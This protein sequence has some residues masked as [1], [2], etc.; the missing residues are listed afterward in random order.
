MKIE[1]TSLDGVLVIEPE[2]SFEDHRGKTVCAFEEGDLVDALIRFW[3]LSDGWPTQF[4]KHN[5][6]VSYKNVLRGIHVSNCYKLAY[7]PFGSIYLVA[8]DCREGS[9]YFGKWLAF[10]ID[11]Y[12]YNLKMILI[13]PGFGLAHLVQSQVAVFFY[14]WSSSF[15]GDKQGGYRWDS[16]GIEWPG[17]SDKFNISERD[18]NA[19]LSYGRP[20]RIQDEPP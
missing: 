7:C 3:P 1:K 17:S 6:S 15:D 5:F 8:V 18:K 10:E 19:P 12:N 11:S 20:R 14:H 4:P 13:P 9:K 2:F 16:F